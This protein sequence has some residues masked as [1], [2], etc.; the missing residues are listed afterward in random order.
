MIIL[1]PHPIKI[2]FY[3]DY[4]RCS[5]LDPKYVYQPFVV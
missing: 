5:A 2:H 1:T 4:E 3:T